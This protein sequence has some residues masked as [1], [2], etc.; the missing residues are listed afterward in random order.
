MQKLRRTLVRLKLRLFGVMGREAL[1]RHHE[2]TARE[3][4]GWGCVY[5]SSHEHERA[6]RP[7]SFGGQH[8]WPNA[9]PWPSLAQVDAAWPALRALAV[10][11]GA[12]P[13]PTGVHL[14]GL[15]ASRIVLAVEAIGDDRG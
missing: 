6:R 12:T 7:Q 8:A 15:D 1:L 3:G 5:V 2:V 11:D 10:G 4:D 14:V 13:Q 9:C